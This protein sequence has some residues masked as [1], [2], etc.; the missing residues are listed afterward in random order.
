MSCRAKRKTLTFQFKPE[1]DYNDIQ[2]SNVSVLHFDDTFKCEG[3]YTKKPL[4]YDTPVTNNYI[5]NAEYVGVGKKLGI[6]T[7]PDLSEHIVGVYMTN[8][9]LAC[10]NY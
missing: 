3:S 5:Q 7:C 6:C 9:T 1:I 2:K 8:N 10:H 4:S